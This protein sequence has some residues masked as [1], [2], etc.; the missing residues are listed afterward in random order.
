[1]IDFIIVHLTISNVIS[2]LIGCFTIA[3]PWAFFAVPK[4]DKESIYACAREEY[5]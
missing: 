5:F 2:F 3:L 1:M 4:K